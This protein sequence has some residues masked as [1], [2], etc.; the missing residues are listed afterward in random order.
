MVRRHLK[1]LG[2]LMY[3]GTAL[4]WNRSGLSVS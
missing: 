3:V 4:A 1:E 2:L